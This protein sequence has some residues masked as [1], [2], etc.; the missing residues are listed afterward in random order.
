MAKN[1][2][3]HIIMSVLFGL[4]VIVFFV[5]FACGRYSAV[6]V[7]DA[8]Q[9]IGHRIF[10][11]LISAVNHETE[12][13]VFQ[14]R[15]PRILGAMLVGAALSISGASY[16]T[17]FANPIASPDTLGVSNAASFGAVLGILIGVGA[18]ASK[19]IAFAFGIGAVLVVF[20][21]ATRI[22]R[23]RNLTIHLLLIGMV[24]SSVFSAL[25]SV[26]KYVADPDD[27]LPQITYWLMGSMSKITM[28]DIKAYAFFFIVGLIPLLLLR[29]RMN[30]LSLSD[31]EILSIGENSFM[32]RAVTVLCATLLT[33]ASTA[34]TGGISWVGLIIPHIVRR[35]IGTDA[36]K[37]LPMSGVLG[38]LFLLIVD[39]LARSISINE[40]PI[41]ILTSLIGAPVFFVTLLRNRGGHTDGC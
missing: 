40:L 16:Q 33:A 9:A 21:A 14:L 27:Q 35:L 7:S 30:L 1:I 10:G 22:D 37:V 24:V 4:L 15:M 5:S 32:L 23:G 20:L 29:W 19:F 41:S 28:Q 36:R 2:R 26:A 17:L 34:M 6:H 8:F 31:A 13:V 25:L 39:N 38:A 12:I 18:T 3:Y 11:N